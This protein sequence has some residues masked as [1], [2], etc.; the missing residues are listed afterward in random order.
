MTKKTGFFLLTASLQNAGSE[1]E[2]NVKQNV[3]QNVEQNVQQMLA[4]YGIKC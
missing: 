3:E 2:Q 1:V 4:E